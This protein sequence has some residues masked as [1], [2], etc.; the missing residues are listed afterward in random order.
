MVAPA[1]TARS[2]TLVSALLRQS[3]HD[4]LKGAI[5]DHAILRIENR[6]S[7]IAAELSTPFRLAITTGAMVLSVIGRIA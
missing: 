4:L 6:G 5:G 3:H 2:E 7:L 1:V